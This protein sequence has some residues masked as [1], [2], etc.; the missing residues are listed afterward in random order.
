M[1]GSSFPRDP[2]TV[3][4]CHMQHSVM[5]IFSNALSLHVNAYSKELQYTQLFLYLLNIEVDK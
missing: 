2:E 4:I 1:N 3:L 5:I